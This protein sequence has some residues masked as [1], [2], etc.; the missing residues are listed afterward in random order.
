MKEQNGGNECAAN[1]CACFSA[2]F[3]IMALRLSRFLLIFLHIVAHICRSPVAAL[4]S[5]FV[6]NRFQQSDLSLSDSATITQTGALCLTNCHHSTNPAI[7]GHAFYPSILQFKKSPVARTTQSFSTHFVFE[8]ESEFQEQGGHGFAFVVSPSTNFSDATGGP[9]LGLFNESNNGNPTNHIFAVEFDTV[10]QA[11]LDDIDGNHV[12]IDV[13][14]VNSSVSESAAYYTDYGK[15]EVVVLDSLTPIQ[16]WIEYDGQMKQLNVTIAPVSHPL[17]PTRSLISYSIDLSSILLEHMYVGFSSGTQRLVSK[18]YI[19]G[20]SF[21]MDEPELDLSSL[22]SISDEAPV[23]KSSK[24]FLNIS[25][26]SVALSFL[27]I[28]AGI[29]FLAYRKRKLTSEKIEGW[30]IDYPH[31]FSYKELYRATKGFKDELGKGG[32]GSVYKGVLPGTGIEVAVKKV[33]HES[34]QGMREFVAEVSS[35]GRMRHRNLVQL[36]G[37][38]RRGDDLLLVYELMPNGSLDGFLFDVK[39]GCLSWEQ[40]FNI[41]KGIASG[42]LYLHEE[43]E[44]VVVHRDVK[45][46]NVLLDG[47]LNGRLSDFGLA[48]LYEHETNPKTTHIVG[49]FGYMAP[50][51]SRTYKSTTSSDVYSYGALLLEVACGRRPFEPGRPSEE[52]ILVELVDSLWKGG[53]ILDAMDKKLENCYVVEEAELVLKLGVLCSQNAPESRP[54]MRQLT[55]FLN[56]DASVQEY[57]NYKDSVIQDDIGMDQNPSSDKVINNFRHSG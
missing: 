54:S 15:M 30:E 26:A 40:R 2:L 52:I 12:G 41:L 4:S 23:W 34:R 56:G 39:A 32:F 47:D 21:K 49:S 6:L 53:R 7:K 50:E 29:F 8:I 28:T 10:Q 55:Q 22:P 57:L 9:Y 11:H 18:H 51:L 43:W 3:L 38:C 36:H 14:G 17:K 1:F 25:V 46:S 35:L 5:I 20:W 31:R 44:Q 16:A 33:S 37:W 19:L 42:L 13:N 45:A 24:L 27:I 48:R